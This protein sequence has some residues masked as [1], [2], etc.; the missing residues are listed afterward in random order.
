MIYQKINFNRRAK[1]LQVYRQIHEYGKDEKSYADRKHKLEWKEIISRNGFIADGSLY[2]PNAVLRDTKLRN[3]DLITIE[4]EADVT[5][6]SEW[7]MINNKV[8]RGNNHCF[9]LHHKNKYEIFWLHKTNPIQFGLKYD[10]SS[11]GDPTRDDF[12][13]GT[14]E[15][16]VPI[17]LKINGKLDTSRGRY[18]KEQTFIFHLL[19]EF[20][21]CFLL[22]ENAIPF[23]K[24][25]P[26]NLKIVSLI[27]PIW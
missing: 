2:L 14:L 16:D 12:L 17:E 26:K 19:G 10:Y 21:S 22:K 27:K 1:I 8:E 25:I 5:F 23:I 20:N 3:C 4:D 11:I 18:Y 24:S 7:K 15:V 13:L 9:N 6:Q